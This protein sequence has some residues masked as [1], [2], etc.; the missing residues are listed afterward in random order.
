MADEFRTTF[1]FGPEDVP[2]RPGILRCVFNTKKRSWK[3]GVQVV[4]ELAQTQLEQLRECGLLGEMTE[5]IRA[6][7]EA[8]T[9][10]EYEQRARELFTQ[11]VCRAKLDLAIAAGIN[12]EN[13]TIA[14][15]ALKEELDRTVI[16]NA[17]T[18]RLAILTELD[19]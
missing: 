10:A 1:F 8:E 2:E 5:M 15:D 11:Q 6:K 14:A 19:L 18:I 13:Q 3:G 4:I 17:D 7:A 12:Q 9:F 16:A